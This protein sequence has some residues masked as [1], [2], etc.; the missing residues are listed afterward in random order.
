LFIHFA[1]GVWYRGSS[2]PIGFLQTL[3]PVSRRSSTTASPRT[4]LLVS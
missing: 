3:S 2:P 1:L 4:G